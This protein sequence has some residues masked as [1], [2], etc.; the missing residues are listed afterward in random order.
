[1]PKTLHNYRAPNL[2]YI[3]I[4]MRVSI[5]N[6]EEIRKKINYFLDRFKARVIFS[7]LGKKPENRIKE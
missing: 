3:I 4:H 1:M 5:G 7:V 6:R 2:L